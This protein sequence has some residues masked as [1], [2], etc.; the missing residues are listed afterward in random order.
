MLLGRDVPDAG[1]LTFFER[2]QA[3]FIVCLR[4]FAVRIILIF[5]IEFE[6][7]VKGDCLTIGAQGELAVRRP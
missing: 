5:A 7:A 6:E 2:W 3:P 4:L 1:I